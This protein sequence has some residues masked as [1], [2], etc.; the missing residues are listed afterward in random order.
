[1]NV[2]DNV[3]LVFLKSNCSGLFTNWR[4]TRRRKK[5]RTKNE[6]KQM[7]MIGENIFLS[8]FT[9][10]VCFLAVKNCVQKRTKQNE[11]QKMFRFWKW[12][13]K[14]VLGNYEWKSLLNEEDVSRLK[15]STFGRQFKIFSFQFGFGWGW[16][17]VVRQ[18]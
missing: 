8:L 4:R 10:C 13:E 9:F 3:K 6:M 1:M 11:N 17:W 18:K 15:H 7:R 5:K 12:R 2:S 16:W 14:N